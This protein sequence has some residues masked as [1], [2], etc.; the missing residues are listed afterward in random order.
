M[1]KIIQCPSCST[2][3]AIQETQIAG[4]LN[5]KFQCS[6]C[7]TVFSLLAEENINSA[8]NPQ[9]KT[10]VN[11]P[12]ISNNTP[13]NSN[14]DLSKIWTF[15]SNTSGEQ[16][17]LGF[18]ESNIKINKNPE[19]E[20]STSGKFGEEKEALDLKTKTKQDSRL[21]KDTINELVYAS[22][23]SNSPVSV[24]WGSQESKNLENKNPQTP[25]RA[26]HRL[27]TEEYPKPSFVNKIDNTKSEEVNLEDPTISSPLNS[28]RQATG[29][30]SNLFRAGGHR[31]S[32]GTFS[33][34]ISISEIISN[35]SADNKDNTFLNDTDKANILDEDAEVN[36]W[37]KL[38]NVI[39]G[40]EESPIEAS[41]NHSSSLIIE[42]GKT[43]GPNTNS[44]DLDIPLSHIK[45]AT[46]ETSDDISNRSM[47]HTTV[48]KR[49][50]LEVEGFLRPEEEIDEDYED[51]N[52]KT[53]KENQQRSSKNKT[54]KDNNKIN[55]GFLSNF[56]SYF[57]SNYLRSIF[58]A[59]SIPS[60]LL[61]FF[62]FYAKKLEIPNNESD[63]S[64]FSLFSPISEVVP[65]VGL[66]LSDLRAELRP[67]K[68]K[69]P[70]VVISGFLLNTTEYSLYDAVL[71]TQ[72]FDSLNSLVKTEKIF[73]PNELNNLQTI[74]DLVKLS[75]D[76]I[77]KLQNNRISRELFPNSKIP[78]KVIIEN[79]E[80][81]YFYFGSRIYS[82]NR[83]P[84]EE[85][86]KEKI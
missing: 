34:P 59:W 6:R 49:D 57:S 27:P 26:N 33:A 47:K 73:I 39:S 4:S 31:S 10:P 23:G 84:S 44:D 38:K 21:D 18:T 11:P 78:F 12:I 85:L 1:T 19:L 5:P 72:L 63:G 41:F 79:I 2:K 81:G 3:F 61:L 74:I 65:P 69:N 53:L 35:T 9:E 30:L 13:K 70:L 80:K 22:S 42:K 48:I 43:V 32:T 29:D 64:E 15:G 55:E 46:E 40:V 51:E 20:S 8:A 83:H 77:K 7:Q 16:L 75:T 36:S 60:F 24:D 17:D 86:T 56:Q 82:V 54:F 76:D 14:T 71:E 28:N 62:Y 67:D 58:V 37:S 45:G 52:D 68:D 50:S 25:N 66:S